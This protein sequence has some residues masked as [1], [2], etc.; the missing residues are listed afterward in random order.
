M[1]LQNALRIEGGAC[2]KSV[3][4]LDGHKS[5]QRGKYG[6]SRLMNV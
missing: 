4:S 1:S 3:C 6:F 5:G 2:G